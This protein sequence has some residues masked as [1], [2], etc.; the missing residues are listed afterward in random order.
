MGPL[1]H[2][3]MFS[4]DLSLGG[5]HQPIRVDPELTGRLAKDA[6]TL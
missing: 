5:N 6:G 1:D 4:Q 3:P 2:P